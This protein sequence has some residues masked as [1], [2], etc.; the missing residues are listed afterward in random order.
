MAG[1]LATY[2][3]LCGERNYARW[4]MYSPVNGLSAYSH[5]P[6]VGALING[7][8]NYSEMYRDTEEML[9]VWPTRMLAWCLR[10]GYLR[11]RN[12]TL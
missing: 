3:I 5:Q 8:S 2:T 10:V 4:S 7:I 9:G 11:I 1:A 12:E 6:L